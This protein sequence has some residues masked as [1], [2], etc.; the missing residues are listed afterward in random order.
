MNTSERQPNSDLQALETELTLTKQ[1][2]E[3]FQKLPEEEQEKRKDERLTKLKRLQSKLDE[4]IQEAVRTG[5][6]EEA[7]RLKEELEKEV[8]DLEE[9][10][11]PRIVHSPE[12]D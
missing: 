1:E 12:N 6:M 7:R 9:Q 2:I 3:E 10:I 4:A 5:E 11:N 8:K